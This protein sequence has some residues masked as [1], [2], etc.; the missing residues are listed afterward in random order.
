MTMRNKKQR[1]TLND[2]SNSVKAGTSNNPVAANDL[3]WFQHNP[4]CRY[5]LRKPLPGEYGSKD[6]P[7]PYR[8]Y[9]LV[10]LRIDQQPLV[11]LSYDGGKTGRSAHYIQ[12]GH[13][14][15][16]CSPAD[17]DFLRNLLGQQTTAKTQQLLRVMWYDWLDSLSGGKS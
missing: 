1:R 2:F 7:E 9:V 13:I 11:T 3:T 14:P 17:N 4:K 16:T 15:V 6:M 5:H 8:W 12:L 10:Q